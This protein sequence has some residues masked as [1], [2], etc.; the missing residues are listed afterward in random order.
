M[1]DDEK[2]LAE[3]QSARH[4]YYGVR[5]SRHGAVA[6]LSDCLQTDP[7]RKDF[8][9]L[10][11]LCIEN[12]VK[13]ADFVLV[14]SDFHI[15][16]D[17]KPELPCDYINAALLERYMTQ[18]YGVN[19]E[20]PETRWNRQETRLKSVAHNFGKSFDLYDW[21]MT[22]AGL[23]AW[24]RVAWPYGDDKITRYYGAAAYAEISNDPRLLRLLVELRP[25]VIDEL[26]EAYGKL[27]RGGQ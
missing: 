9:A 5:E 19:P 4:A 18:G 22:A 15:G 7:L 13:A 27:Y 3:A 26:E 12:A 20:P 25:T 6:G 17:R 16:H 23:E 2:V 1:L 10:A 14:A 11:K 8:V 21:L 24:F